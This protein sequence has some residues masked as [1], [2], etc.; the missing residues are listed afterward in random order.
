MK[1]FQTLFTDYIIQKNFLYIFLGV[2]PSF[3]LHDNMM[4]K[5]KGKDQVRG[6]IA[7][8]ILCFADCKV[9]QRGYKVNFSRIGDFTWS[10]SNCEELVGVIS[11]M[12]Y[13]V[14][15]FYKRLTPFTYFHLQLPSLSYVVMFQGL[16]SLNSP[17]PLFPSGKVNVPFP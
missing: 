13:L 10:L 6:V 15:V 9:V 3:L 5:Q 12:M 14:L 8:T 4:M 7:T 11:E 17:T 2:F 16:L 1:D